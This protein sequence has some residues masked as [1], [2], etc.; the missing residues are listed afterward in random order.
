[1]RIN[2]VDDVNILTLKHKGKCLNFRYYMNKYCQDQEDKEGVIE[3]TDFA[4]VD[5][6]I[7]ML[8]KY[9]RESLECIGKWDIW[10]G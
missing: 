6:L 7:S 1:M 5:A 10:E 4:E 8:Q 3:F 2:N 9:R